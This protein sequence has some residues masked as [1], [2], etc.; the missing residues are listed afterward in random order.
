MGQELKTI[1]VGPSGPID[2]ISLNMDLNKLA[3]A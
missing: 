3:I 1:N 2:N